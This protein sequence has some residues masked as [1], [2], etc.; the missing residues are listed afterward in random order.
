MALLRLTRRAV[1]L[2]ALGAA[3]VV[4]ARRRAE[5]R[6]QIETPPEAPSQAQAPTGIE[7]APEPSPIEES[8]IEVPPVED[9]PIEVPPVEDPPIEE[10]PVEPA[11][12]VA[13]NNASYEKLKG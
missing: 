5:A 1:P 2:L 12:P 7:A 8:P 9:P 6:A 13:V 3:G 4:L 11:P 10:A